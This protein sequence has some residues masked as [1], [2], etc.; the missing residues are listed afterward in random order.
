MIGQHPITGKEIR[1]IN[2]ETHLYRDK[3]TLVWL[4]D[5]EPNPRYVRWETLVTSASDLSK[6]KTILKESPTLFVCNSLDIAE[7]M[8]DVWSL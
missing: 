6:W 4:R 8:S 5:Q 2:T 1:I 7:C 3:K